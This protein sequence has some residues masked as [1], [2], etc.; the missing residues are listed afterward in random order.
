MKKNRPLW[1]IHPFHIDV[2]AHWCLVS[3]VL[4]SVFDRVWLFDEQFER[5]TGWSSVCRRFSSTA[6]DLI[7]QNIPE[8]GDVMIIGNLIGWNDEEKYS[9]DQLSDWSRHS[10]VDYY[11]WTGPDP[12]K[13]I[14]LF[15]E[16]DVCRGCIFK[17]NISFCFKLIWMRAP[18][19]PSEMLG[20]V[21]WKKNWIL[22]KHKSLS[23]YF[24]P[25]AI[26]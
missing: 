17:R 22:V 19:N 5:T 18:P 2:P 26:I 13:V 25:F 10:P 23:S 15:F 11:S 20:R 21:K 1:Q 4:F 16:V 24:L 3:S 14:E 6:N 8:N 9:T 7:D 12:T